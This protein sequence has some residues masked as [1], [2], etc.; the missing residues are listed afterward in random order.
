MQLEQPIK[1]GI[2]NL[3]F[4]LNSNDTLITTLTLLC[5]STNLVVFVC[6]D[7]LRKASCMCLY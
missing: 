6:V 3:T 4:I 7:V 2:L 5:F 1:K